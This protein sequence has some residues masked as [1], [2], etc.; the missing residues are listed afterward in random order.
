MA[1][2][3]EQL[4][5]MTVAQLRDIA[6]GIE[7]EAVKGYSTMHKEKLLPALCHALSIETHAHHR[8]MG[9]NKTEIK[10]E[11]RKLKAERVAA[12]QGDDRKQFKAVLRK[13]HHLKRRLR[14][15]IV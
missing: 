4:S 11:I 8:V 2:T 6:R 13:I 5:E 3:Y 7:H 1:Y 15:S 14:K 10:A 9:I 12:L